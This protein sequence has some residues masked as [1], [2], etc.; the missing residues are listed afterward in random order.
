MEAPPQNTEP[1]PVRGLVRRQ[2]LATVIV[3]VGALWT[4]L[5]GVCTGGF[6][7][8]TMGVALIIGGPLVLGG[9]AIWLAG[10]LLRGNPADAAVRKWA[11]IWAVV[12]ALGTIAA[13][14]LA[15]W[16]G[17]QDDEYGLSRMMAIFAAAGALGGLVLLAA[18]LRTLAVGRT[19]E[20]P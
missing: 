11:R 8:L 15:I 7:L 14:S 20:E 19:V 16:S 5:T 6:A 12:S 4:L 13:I 9:V 18:S 3:V 17:G 1:P 2:Q 10:H